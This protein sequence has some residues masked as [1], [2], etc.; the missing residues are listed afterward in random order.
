[1]YVPLSQQASS[2]AQQDVN[3]AL[4]SRHSIQ[5]IY[6]L[7]TDARVQV[8]L[9]N[10]LGRIAREFDLGTLGQGTHTSRLDVSKMPAGIYSLQLIRGNSANT[11][12]QA[13]VLY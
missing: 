5:L 12:R 3:V 13:V 1:M 11:T 2:P 10:A 7:R 9:V 6:R 8:K 4:T